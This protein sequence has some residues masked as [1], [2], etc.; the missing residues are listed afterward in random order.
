VASNARERGEVVSAELDLLA[1][2]LVSSLDLY[3]DRD[4]TDPNMLLWS[5]LLEQQAKALDATVR[6]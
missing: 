4:D 5:A 3:L 6:A 2:I 1:K